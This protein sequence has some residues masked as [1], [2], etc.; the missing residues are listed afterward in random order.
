VHGRLTS[1][2]VVAAGGN[3]TTS[4]AYDAAGLVTRI[5]QPNGAYLDFTY[6]AAQRLTQIANA[7]GIAVAKNQRLE[8]AWAK[9][10]AVLGLDVNQEIDRRLMAERRR[11]GVRRKS[12]A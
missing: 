2:T 1:H 12:V 8:D 6:D 9:R 11:D 7:H 4:I 3:A 5:T 10:A